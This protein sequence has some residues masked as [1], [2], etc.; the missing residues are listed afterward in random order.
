MISACNQ[1]EQSSHKYPDSAPTDLSLRV[2]PF[3]FP[4][5]M[6]TQ[7]QTL[8]SDSRVRLYPDANGD[9]VVASTLRTAE[10]VE[11][12]NEARAHAA[13]AASATTDLTGFDEEQIRLMEEVCIVVDKD[14]MPMGCG[15]KKRC[16][17]NVFIDLSSSLSPLFIALVE[18]IC[19]L[20]SEAK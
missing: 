10:L 13:S 19:F 3:V 8:A 6:A 12:G 16:M 1:T 18:I 14:D 17:C 20:F 7:T 4:T 5:P 9:A 2:V 15:S 11:D